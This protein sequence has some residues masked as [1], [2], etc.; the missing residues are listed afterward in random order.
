[1]RTPTLLLACSLLLL[2]GSRLY[3]Q[4]EIRHNV[5]FDYDKDKLTSEARSSLDSLLNAL[6]LAKDMYEV[7]LIGH[8]DSDGDYKYNQDLSLR[9]SK[10]VR[11][12]FVETGGFVES[13]IVL[14]G[15]SYTEPVAGNE[16][17]KGKAK[18]RRVEIVLVAKLVPLQVPTERWTF[19]A[20]EG[21]RYVYERSGS[22][23]HIPAD[24]LMR[25]DGSPAK[26]EARLEYREFRD[27]ADFIA[28]G[29]TM[30]YG[31][32]WFDSGGMFEVR[33]FQGNEELRLPTYKPL[34][35]EF[36]LTDTLPNLN[37]YQFQTAS[38]QWV[39][40][41][42]ID[43]SAP[44]L[45]Y[46]TLNPNNPNT[47]NAGRRPIR[48]DCFVPFVVKTEPIKDTLK[49]YFDAM[50]LGAQLAHS[51]GALTEF[52][53]TGFVEFD[54]RWRQSNNYK[55]FQYAGTK[56][57]G[58]SSYMNLL[59]NKEFYS[60]K[61][62]PDQ[63]KVDQNTKKVTFEIMDLGNN[64]PEIR[65]LKDR[66]WSF[67]TRSGTQKGLTRTHMFL[68][69]WSDMRLEHKGGAQFRLTI[70]GRDQYIDM[71][72]TAELEGK[73]KA[74]AAETYQNIQS[75]YE[76]ALNRHRRALDDSMAFARSNWGYFLAFSKVFMPA[77]EQCMTLKEWVT[78]FENNIQVMQMRYDSLWNRPYSSET[79]QWIRRCMS[80]LPIS[81][82][83]D[84]V[85][86]VEVPPFVR[87]LSVDGFGV[88]NCDQ[89]ERL[90]NAQPLI[91]TYVD[92]SGNAIEAESLS[93]VDYSINSVLTFPPNQIA[94]NPQSKTALLVSAKDGKK[95][96]LRAAQFAALPL[97][98][99]K[100]YTFQMEDVTAQ[101]RS[102]DDLRE[103]LR[104]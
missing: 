31:D 41:G 50:Q 22:V 8:T 96:L 2:S 97:K 16:T 71:D 65:T 69:N 99:K 94:Y 83:L 70:K 36:R 46:Q 14:D 23:I 51:P 101:L 62:K 93:L 81:P 25:A 17:D 73:E 26:G 58:T 53:N 79:Q 89:I 95:Y 61:L 15:K 103:M 56:Y 5:H 1:M 67:D 90:G 78:H 3:A 21:L 84:P 57:T 39:D 12:Y 4:N 48:Q 64:H 55:N 24:A 42:R 43:A 66:H 32:G 18:N 38:G 72:I 11:G 77:E 45:E 68:S 63:P 29:I 102:V 100:N 80:G 52:F 59:N 19:R 86:P 82:T 6:P 30:R 98:G 35:I 91:A 85:T 33:V 9:R 27:P 44:R 28:F 54:K 74:N 20:E 76:S 34:E 87:V 13:Q 92:P 37:F 104:L 10:T 7:H 75:R 40:L 49:T 47:G 88:F 60:V